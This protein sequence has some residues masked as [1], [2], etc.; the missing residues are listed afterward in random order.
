MHSLSVMQL[1]ESLESTEVVEEGPKISPKNKGKLLKKFPKY[2]SESLNISI[3][4]S[5]RTKQKQPANLVNA[6]ASGGGQNEY[7]WIKWTK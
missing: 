2:A 7:I 5:V 3:A 4:S 6:M 1:E